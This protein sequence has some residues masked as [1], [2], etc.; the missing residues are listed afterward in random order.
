[1]ARYTGHVA[2]EAPLPQRLGKGATWRTTYRILGPFTPIGEPGLT[3]RAASV[4]DL[5]ASFTLGALAPAASI[6]VDVQNAFDLRYVENRASGFIT[7]GL[8]RV[9]RVAIR[10]GAASAARGDA[11]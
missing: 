7:P 11:H 1:V 2:T 3:T 6:D 5:G 9:L 10:I 4:L 8:P